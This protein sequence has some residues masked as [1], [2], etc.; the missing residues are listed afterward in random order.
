VAGPA[1]GGYLPVLD[2]PD[3]LEAELVV[4]FLA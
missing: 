4:D 1:S 3:V 2:V